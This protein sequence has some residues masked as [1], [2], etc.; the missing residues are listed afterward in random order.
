MLRRGPPLGVPQRAPSG[1]SRGVPPL[2]PAGDPQNRQVPENPPGPPAGQKSA[3]FVG[4]LINLPFGTNM[5]HEFLGFFAILGQT[6]DPPKRGLDTPQNTP[7][8][9]PPILTVNVRLEGPKTPFFGVPYGSQ[10]DPFWTPL[11]PPRDPPRGAP[12]PGGRAG[13]PGGPPGRPGAPGAKIRISR[14]TQGGSLGVPKTAIFGGSR[15]PP[16]GPPIEPYWARG[17][18]PPLAS[19]STQERCYGIDHAALLRHACRSLSER[20]QC[21]RMVRLG[22]TIRGGHWT[23][24]GRVRR[25]GAR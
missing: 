17:S 11:R 1:G 19:P 9:G 8:L 24:I 10:L 13:G 7:P 3:H 14:P 21:R 6:W 5:G 20:T 16:M 2:G 23:V 15:V 22:S 18:Q 4:Y 25:G 12:R